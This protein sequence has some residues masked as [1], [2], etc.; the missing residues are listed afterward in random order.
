MTLPP[1]KH[2]GPLLVVWGV[3]MLML[4]FIRDL[5]SS[6][7]FFGAFLALLYV[8]TDRGFVHRDR[9]RDVR[10]LGR[11]SSPGTV[12]HVGERVDIWL[13]PPNSRCPAS[14]RV[15][16]EKIS[17]ITANL[18]APAAFSARAHPPAAST[19]AASVSDARSAISGN[20]PS[21]MISNL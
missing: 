1:L 8:A 21:N 4:I 3:A 10:S 7:M 2:F 15:R 14:E 5:G 17:A 19:N 16:R 20:K 9:P 18:R 13:D 6:L 12:P 11:G